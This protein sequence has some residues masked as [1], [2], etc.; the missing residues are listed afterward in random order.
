VLPTDKNEN[1]SVASFQLQPL[2]CSMTVMGVGIRK[3]FMSVESDCV[4]E[5]RSPTGLLFIYQMIH[6]Y[7][8]PVE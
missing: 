8:A 1:S 4:S 2:N 3:L 6:G 7:R 5:L